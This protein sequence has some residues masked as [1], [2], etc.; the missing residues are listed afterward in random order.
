MSS[1]TGGKRLGNNDINVGELYAIQCALWRLSYRHPADR[2]GTQVHIF[3]DSNETFNFLTTP[4]KISKYYRLVQQTRRYA[5]W[6]KKYEFVMHWIPSHL[7]GMFEIKGNSTVDKLAREAALTGRENKYEC[8]EVG[9][10]N[11]NV[12]KS[13]MNA[14]ARLV[15]DIEKLFPRE[16]GPASAREV[17]SNEAKPGG[18]SVT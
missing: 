13:V 8:D 18:S 1:I 10:D 6:M 15:H 9:L 17:T 16:S 2:K 5:A 3:T 4:G 7:E 11:L 12:H 14:A